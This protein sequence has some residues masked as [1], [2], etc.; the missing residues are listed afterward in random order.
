M[1]DSM[2]KYLCLQVRC[3]KRLPVRHDGKPCLR[4]QA[5]TH[6]QSWRDDP[7]IHKRRC[8]ILIGAVLLY[9]FWNKQKSIFSPSETVDA[10]AP[11]SNQITAECDSVLDSPSFRL[12][13]LSIPVSNAWLETISPSHES[14]TAYIQYI[15]W[16]CDANGA[17]KQL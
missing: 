16:T 9:C 2:P 11:M 10:V 13:N 8:S 17:S 5:L 4:K 6:V 15:W 3:Q 14:M 12:C 1:I 7:P